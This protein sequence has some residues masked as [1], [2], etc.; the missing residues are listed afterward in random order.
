[1][2]AYKNYNH[3]RQYHT[4]LLFPTALLHDE[5]NKRL[6]T[7]RVAAS[8][9]ASR[10]AARTPR[11]PLSLRAASLAIDKRCN[12]IKNKI[13]K[14]NYIDFSP[15]LPFSTPLTLRPMYLSLNS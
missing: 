13:N 14:K 2:Y 12:T 10:S 7:T 5:N 9:S 1:M 11:A 8:S 4:L 3:N 6:T 15:T